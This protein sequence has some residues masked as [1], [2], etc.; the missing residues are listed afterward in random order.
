MLTGRVPYEADSTVGIVMK[1]ISAPVPDITT[2][3]P[4]LP[5]ALNPVMRRALAKDP[6]E[7]YQSAQELTTAVA[8]ALGTSVLTGPILSRALDQS[9]STRPSLFSRRGGLTLWRKLMLLARWLLRRLQPGADPVPERFGDLFQR[10]FPTRRQRNLVWGSLL[11][12]LVATFSLASL[13]SGLAPWPAASPARTAPLSTADLL[14]ATAPATAD[15]QATASAALALAGATATAEMAA[16]T[17]AAQQAAAS[18]TAGA[19]L[20]ATAAS[21]ATAA[22]ASPTPTAAATRVVWSADGMSLAYVPP[23]PFLFGSADGDGAASD[24]EKP[25]VQIEMDGYW[26]DRTEVTV[27]QFQIFVDATDYETDAER[28]C[29]DGLYA[30]PGG[31]VYSPDPLYVHNASWRLP[32]GS[33]APEAL[34]RH[35]VVQVSWNDA[36]AYCTWAGR[37]L[38]TEAEWE[39]AAR[40]A[41]G[42]IYPWGDEFDGR[43]LNY[44]DLNCSA[45]WH[46]TIDDTFPRTGTAGVFAT[47]A[48]PYDVLDLSGNVWE[49]INDFYDFRGYA[50]VPTANPPGLGSGLTHVLRGGSWLDPLERVRAATRA[51]AVPD[52]RNNLSGFRCAVSNVP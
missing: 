31:F 19:A 52:A 17:Q 51:S 30:D 2:T 50:G 10:L 39:K 49:W 13:L 45:A 33:G 23:G 34:P 3:W 40:G 28:G 20:N 38:P 14:S 27:E 24:D 48:S 6:V 25:Q 44:C 29:C 1:H 22:A 18:E 15:G 37:R 11:V 36:I 16:A 42:L 26:I 4:E 9:R 12:V 41:T 43:R 5:E 47:G 46:G 8:E 21:V 35:P 7:R 32:Q